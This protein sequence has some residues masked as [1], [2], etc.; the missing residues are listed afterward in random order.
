MEIYSDTSLFVY[1]EEFEEAAEILDE[2]KS[3][4]LSGTPGSGKTA[5]G[6]ALLR[7]FADKGFRPYVI[8][9]VHDVLLHVGGGG[10]SVLLLDGTLGEVRVDR[11]EHRQWRG[12]LRSLS[13]LCQS[14]S[15]LLVLTAYPHVVRELRHLDAG[16]GSPLSLPQV[17]IEVRLP[18]HS[19]KDKV[20][21]EML[22]IH[23]QGVDL[24]PS[25]KETLIADVLKNDLSGA[26][27]PWCC[28][29]MVQTWKASPDHKAIFQAPAEAY[30]SMLRRMLL[31][32]DH[33]RAFAA[34][35]TLTMKGHSHFLHHPLQCQPLLF[36]LGFGDLSDFKLAEY[37]DFLKGSILSP[38][39]DT[40]LNRVLYDAVGLAMGAHFMLPV[41]LKV[42]DFTFLETHVRTSQTGTEFTIN[43]GQN[44]PDRQLLFV[45][46]MEE[47]DSG[48]RTE[49]CRHPAIADKKIRREYFFLS[50]ALYFSLCVYF[51]LIK[52]FPHLA[53]TRTQMCVR[54]R[55]L[56]WVMD[57]LLLC[58]LPGLFAFLGGFSWVFY[59]LP[60]MYLIFIQN[61]HKAVLLRHGCVPRKRFF[62]LLDIWSIIKCNVYKIIMNFV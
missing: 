2:H 48:H 14:G 4:V 26:A 6:H 28:R 17:E 10:K 33:G 43:I 51:S 1:T 29:Q 45:R 7:K 55:R 8:T 57:S 38:E 53:C 62:F 20:K 56:W 52:L 41:L 42:C 40:F 27:F 47:V 30:A 44:I 31:D 58:L 19:L 34:I 5:L 23:L 59:I 12:L 61:A 36:D 9:H 11:Q 39:G 16:T 54:L 49:I 18:R 21:R 3:V 32:P 60:L 35:L 37:A 25:S 46:F 15:C 22:A 24:D 50:A 13:H